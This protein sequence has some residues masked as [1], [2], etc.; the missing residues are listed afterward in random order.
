MFGFGNV[1][2]DVLNATLFTD[3]DSYA[4]RLEESIGVRASMPKLVYVDDGRLMANGPF[5]LG[6]LFRNPGFGVDLAAEYHFT[7]K[8]GIVAAVHD[9]GFIH[10]GLNNI[11]MKGQVN[12][13][14]Q[15]YDDGDFLFEGM[16]AD[17]LQRIISDDWYR[18]QFFDTL[19]QYF[20]VDLGVS[21]A[22]NT[23]LN[24]NVLLRAYVDVNPYNRFSAQVQ[25]T[26]YNSGFRPAL[27]LAYSGSFFNKI[28]VC[29][30]YTMMK[31]SYDN[32][33]L[34]LA[35]NL[36]T[37]HIY[38]AS[39]NVIGLFKPLNT[40]GLNA[41]FGIVFNLWTPERKISKAKKDGSVE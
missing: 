34:G 3:A 7:D 9:L 2:T 39:N 17:Q 28:D 30:T 24:T 1:K 29:A 12:D 13:A 26:F 20:K 11:E 10:W 5:K 22:Y 40:S 33:G 6:E 37:F 41:Q 21:K 19:R 14:G 25:G 38:A 23:M 8:F 32:I 35:F 27:T 18:E 36:G 4:L 31:E 15:F 16:D